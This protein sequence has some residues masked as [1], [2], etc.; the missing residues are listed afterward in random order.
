MPGAQFWD[1]WDKVPFGFTIWYH[2]PLGVMVLGLGYR[3]G[4]P[5]NESE[6]SNPEFDEL[7]TK[8]EGTLDVDKRREIMGRLE[9]IMYE[10]GP[11]T[12]PFWKSVV[13]FY[14][15]KVK[16]AAAHP[17]NYIFAEQMAIES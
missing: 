14:D 3:S 16:G 8:A 13:T 2:R 10:D 5:W 15:E 4:V 6:Y 17:T 11:I 7:L 12:Q 1:I 9:Q